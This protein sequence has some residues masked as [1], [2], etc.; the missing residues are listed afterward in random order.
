MAGP[1]RGKIDCYI[2]TGSRY[3][4]NQNL[5]KN[6]YDFCLSHPNM[7]LIAR[8]GGVSGTAASVDYHDGTNPFLSNAWFVFRMN[9]ATLESGAAN[10]YAY[11]GTRTYP[12]YIYCQWCR[13]DQQNWN[14]GSSNP[15]S[16][17]GTTS[18]GGGSAAVGAQFAIPV[19][20]TPGTSEVAWNGAGTLGTNT[21]GSPVWR[22]TAGTPAGFQGSYVFP[23]SSSPGGSYNT[24][25]EN[26]ISVNF[27]SSDGPYRQHIIADDDSLVLVT[28]VDDDGS[29]FVCYFGLYTLRSGVSMTYPMVC[30]H[31]TIPQAQGTNFGTTT[32]LFRQGGIALNTLTDNVRGV[33][34]SRLDDWHNIFSQPNNMFATELYDEWSIPVLVNESPS[35]FGLVGQIDFV[36]EVYDWSMN[37][38]NTGRTRIALG[39]NSSQGTKLLLPW[40]GTAIPRQNFTRAGITF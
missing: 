15:S 13:G 25:R 36:R 26:C 39:S 33:Q 38:S 3:T 5:F 7:S 14:A 16:I 18:I 28:D 22:T 2:N 31:D 12:W 4:N 10:P 1:V 21:K 11:G 27:S 37:D 6:I 20:T 8:Y 35:F 9:D 34:F 40:N 24:N 29:P 19:G 30:W 23:R 32:G 17:D